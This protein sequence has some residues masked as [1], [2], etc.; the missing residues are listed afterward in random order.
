MSVF[1]VVPRGIIPPLVTPLRPDATLDESGLERLIEHVLAGGVHALFLLGTTGEG[2]SLSYP[3]R[4]EMIDRTCR[5]VRNRVPVLVCISDTSLAESLRV[6]GWAA[7]AGADAVVAAP[8]YYY[9]ASQAELQPY[10]DC[11][12]TASPL[13][14]LLYNMPAMTKVTIDL[15][16]VRRATDHPRIVGLKDSSLSMGYLHQVQ[17]LRRVRTDWRVFVGDEE[18]LAY[19]VQAG[20]DG[21]VNG[22]A[23]VFP[24]LYVQFYEAAAAGDLVRCE[25]LR[26]LVVRLGELYR[27]GKRHAASGI[28]GIKSA[29]SLLGICDDAV[30]PPLHRFQE[31]E[32]VRVQQVLDE[33][34]RDIETA[35]NHCPKTALP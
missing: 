29:L 28:K 35:A 23:N 32:R 6:A 16:T 8:P 24:K 25:T 19:A 15:D 11:L 22:G 4:R 31:A 7:D 14:L 2:P 3:L 26:A 33:L 5:R 30:A 21:G 20:A 9:P 27:I 13:P 10:F 34:K 17:R 12:A 1:P 18:T